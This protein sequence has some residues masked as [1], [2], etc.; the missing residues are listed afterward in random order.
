VAYVILFCACFY[1]NKG[2]INAVCI[3]A[4][5][6]GKEKLIFMVLCPAE[7]RHKKIKIC[8]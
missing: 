4:G 1:G 2:K 3:A 7:L 8:G 6:S 5:L